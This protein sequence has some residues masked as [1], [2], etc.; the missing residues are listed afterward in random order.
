M[1]EYN[2]S[3]RELWWISFGA[4]ALNA[5]KYYYRDV[6][7]EDVLIE[8]IPR[9]DQ[10]T[11]QP[12]RIMPP[13]GRQTFLRTAKTNSLTSNGVAR[14]FTQACTV[15]NLRINVG[16]T[17][18]AIGGVNPGAF[19]AVVLVPDGSVL[20]NCNVDGGI[21]DPARNV[22]IFDYWSAALTDSHNRALTQEMDLPVKVG[23]RLFFCWETVAITD[24]YARAS[25][26]WDEYY[27]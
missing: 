26:M 1:S 12:G 8:D 16:A 6:D 5:A 4:L 20:G 18:E 10:M 22:L 14:T 13:R 24:W 23:D 17:I 19:F 3:E 9:G 21:Y 11:A 25:L 15:K 7:D 2:L 27:G